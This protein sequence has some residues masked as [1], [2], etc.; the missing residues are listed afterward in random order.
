M[1]ENISYNRIPNEYFIT[2][3]YGSSTYEQHA[4]S[5]HIALHKAGIS[6]Y[7]IQVYSSILPAIATEIYKPNNIPFGSELYTIMSCI[8]GGESEYISCGIGIGE[9]WDNDKKI[10]SLVVEVSGNYDE[11]TELIDRLTLVLKDLHDETY[12][13]YEMK[14]MQFITNSYTPH[15]RFGTCLVALCFTSFK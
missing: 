8:N 10:G 7:N 11:Y 6:D 2:K 13:L 12:Y 15:E 3:G 9:L 1:T 14:N 5:L 4:G